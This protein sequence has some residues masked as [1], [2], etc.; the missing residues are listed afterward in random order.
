MPVLECAEA[1]ERAVL[2]PINGLDLAAQ[3]AAR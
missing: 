1:G 2:R 3:Y